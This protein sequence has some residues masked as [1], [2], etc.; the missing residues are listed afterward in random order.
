MLLVALVISFPLSVAAVSAAECAVVYCL[1]SVSSR[2]SIF[3][4]FMTLYI[5]FYIGRI[6]SIQYLPVD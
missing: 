5:D 1:F 4:Q 3:T 6:I 2:L